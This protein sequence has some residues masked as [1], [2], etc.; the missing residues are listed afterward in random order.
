MTIQTKPYTKWVGGKAWLTRSHAALLPVPTPGGRV[1]IPFVGGGAVAYHYAG[2]APLLLSDANAR[3]IATYMAVRDHAVALVDALHAIEQ[4]GY[5]REAFLAIRQRMNA[6][7]DASVVDMA[8]WFITI[9]RW[10]FNG[11]WRVNGSGA[12]NVPFGKPSKAGTV[13]SLV[14]AENLVS[15]GFGGV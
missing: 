10:G 2:K 4:G 9:N 14:D 5:T 7:P 3:L 8:A 15:S 11:L 6:E 1:C 12:C 13:P